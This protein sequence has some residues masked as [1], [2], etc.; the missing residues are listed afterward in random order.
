MSL[1]FPYCALVMTKIFIK[2]LSLNVNLDKIELV[3]Y[4]ALREGKF[5]I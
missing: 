4:C 5:R 1:S 2:V 3:Y